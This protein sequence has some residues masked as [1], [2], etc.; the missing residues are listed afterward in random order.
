MPAQPYLP[1]RLDHIAKEALEGDPDAALLLAKRAPC[2]SFLTFLARWVKPGDMTADVFDRFADAY[3]RME[4]ER[5]A[6]A[7]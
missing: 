1:Q 6:A 4:M 5:E 2:S 7:G 3:D